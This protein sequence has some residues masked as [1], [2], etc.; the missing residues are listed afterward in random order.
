MDPLVKEFRFDDHRLNIELETIIRRINDISPKNG[1]TDTD[2]TYI[3]L[4]NAD[5]EICY[6]YPNATQTDIIVSATKP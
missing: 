5:G 1:V 3:T 2:I 6:I 4:K